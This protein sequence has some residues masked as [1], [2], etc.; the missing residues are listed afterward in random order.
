MDFGIDSNYLGMEFLHRYFLTRREM[1]DL[2]LLDS[3]TFYS[4]L[5]SLL[6]TNTHTFHS[7]YML[8]HVGFKYDLA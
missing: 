6:Q 3:Y 1:N 7:I 2:I 4:T 5:S 8:T